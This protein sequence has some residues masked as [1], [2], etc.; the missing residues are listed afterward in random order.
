MARRYEQSTCDVICAP[1]ASSRR[2]SKSLLHRLAFRQAPYPFRAFVYA[3]GLMTYG[4]DPIDQLRQAAT[5]VDRI[6]KGTRPGDLPV[7]APTKFDL[8]LNLKTAR[9]Q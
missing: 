2:R 3:G 8:V 4:V 5:Y 7:Q 6:L 9:A 1:S